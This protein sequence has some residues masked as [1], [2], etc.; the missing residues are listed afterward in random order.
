[1]GVGVVEVVKGVV[2]VL[3]AVEEAGVS[4]VAGV[5]GVGTC[6]GGG[7]SVPG[8]A[9]SMCAG[10]ALCGCTKVLV[11]VKVCTAPF[12]DEELR[13][14]GSGRGRDGWEDACCSSRESSAGEGRL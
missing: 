11:G 10:V 1:M 4:V 8:V 2:G 12:A 6:V 5:E 13:S 14:R 9:K 3:G 7:R